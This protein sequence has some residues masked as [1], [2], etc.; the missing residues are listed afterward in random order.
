M[1]TTTVPA[2]HMVR[3]IKA[4]RARV[5][6]AWTQPE[7]LKRWCAPEGF[8]IPNAEVDLRVGG[9]YR[10]HMRS[11]DGAEHIAFGTY[12]EIDS[13]ARLVFTWQWEKAMGEEQGET[14]VTLEFHQRGEHT[15]V[16]LVHDGFRTEQGPTN[17][18]K[19]WTSCLNR[20]ENLFQ[21]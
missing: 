10:I 19:G 1:K 18:E 20:L 11:P 7:E 9:S 14:T 2:L 6:Q 8:T 5:F 21:G 3:K 13:P 12:R 16:V 15:E 4:D 17:H